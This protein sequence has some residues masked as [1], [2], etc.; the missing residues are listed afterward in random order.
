MQTSIENL[1]LFPRVTPLSYEMVEYDISATDKRKVGK[2]CLCWHPDVVFKEKN[3][4][5]SKD[6][7]LPTSFEDHLEQSHEVSE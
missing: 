5:D 1:Y 4:D 7:D 6:E 3:L 2:S